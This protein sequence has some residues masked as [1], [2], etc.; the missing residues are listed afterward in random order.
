MMGS[1]ALGSGAVLKKG[2]IIG[3]AGVCC[4]DYIFVSS[5]PGGQGGTSWVKE[6]FFQG[7]GLVGTAV[8]TA[9]RLGAP[10][11]L[12]SMVG[13]DPPGEEI[14]RELKEEKVDVTGVRTIKGGDSPMSMI[15]VDETS[16]ERTIFHR[17]VKGLAWP[18]EKDMQLIAKCGALLVD[19]Y[20]MDL[21]LQ[22]VRIAQEAGVPTVVDS[23]PSEKNA[24]LLRQVDVLVAP[25]DFL[26]QIGC[27][28]DVSA[29]L[30][31][32]HALGPKTAV[33]TLGR[34]GWV[35][36]GPDGE[37]RGDA[38]SVNVVDTTGAG[39]VYHGA[40]AFALAQGWATERCC[41]FA[42]GVA[43]IKCTQRGGRTGIPSLK[44]VLTL[45]KERSVLNW[46]N[47]AEH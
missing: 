4:Q 7:G 26:R 31:R 17:R 14:L 41:D 45:L 30:K 32:I 24:D 15:H 27:E 37:G 25:Q 42:A 33:I 2:I 11:R 19:D 40:F 20:Y 9:A 21:S 6:V 44:T 23:I 36:S 29:G 35:C 8:V 28:N 13:D 34:R 5:W 1:G 3:G 47:V 39:D 10:C 22:A 38:Y 18:V 16:G 46:E 43:A 12:W